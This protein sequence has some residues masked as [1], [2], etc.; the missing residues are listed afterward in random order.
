MAKVG[1]L[2]RDT[3]S[4]YEG[5]VICRA[6]NLY[7]NSTCNVQPKGLNEQGEPKTTYRFAEERLEVVEENAVI[8]LR[9][10][11]VKEIKIGPVNINVA[12]H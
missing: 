9:Q 10:I 2:V 3:I 8:S 11:E 12:D 7:E 1:D 5:I 4:G 6:D